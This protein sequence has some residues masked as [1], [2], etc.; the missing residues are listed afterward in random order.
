MADNEIL[1]QD[2]R[3]NYEELICIGSGKHRYNFTIFLNL[4]PFVD[5]IH[6][7]SLSLKAANIKQMNTE[8]MIGRLEEYNPNKEKFIA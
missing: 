7:S 8:N 5:C 3:I 1:K 6:D 2:K 4:K